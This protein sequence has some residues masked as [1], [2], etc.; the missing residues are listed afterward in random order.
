[1]VQ[2]QGRNRTR[3]K[4]SAKTCR[5][6]LEGSTRI[7]TANKALPGAQADDELNNGLSAFRKPLQNSWDNW[8]LAFSATMKKMS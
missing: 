7:M 1:M 6:Q 3:G 4:N 8:G 2:V 5:L